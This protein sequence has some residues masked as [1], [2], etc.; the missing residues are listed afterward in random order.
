M[1]GPPKAARADERPISSALRADTVATR[2]RIVATAERLFAARGLDSVS[3]S[4]INRAARQRNRSAVQYHFGSKEGLVHAILDKHTPGIERR[5]HA[6]L[7]ELESSGRITL[8]ALAEALVVPVA[9]KLDDPDGGGAFVRLNA[10]LIGH[11]KFPLLALNAQRVNRGGDRLQ[12]LTAQVA[13]P[14]PKPLRVPLWLLVTGLLFHGIADYA[15]LAARDGAG[16]PV[17]PRD[18]FVSQLVDSVVA[19]LAAPVSPETAALLGRD[20]GSQEV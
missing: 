15:H 7:D 18:L 8:R 2:A 1:A 19:L 5:R 4:E 13:P 11:P 12:R 3:V 16:L 14:L 9:E 10:Q 17:P 6:M 20:S